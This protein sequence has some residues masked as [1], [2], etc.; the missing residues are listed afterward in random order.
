M[1]KYSLVLYDQKDPILLTGDCF[2]NRVAKHYSKF[3]Q[4]CRGFACVGDY[5][6]YVYLF[7]QNYLHYKCIA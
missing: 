6:I 3:L 5:L 4:V 7:I 1:L 2:A